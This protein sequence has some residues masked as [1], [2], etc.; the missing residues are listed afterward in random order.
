MRYRSVF[1]KTSKLFFKDM[2]YSFINK[3]IQALDKRFIMCYYLLSYVGV[4][5]I[6]GS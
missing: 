2:V 4:I 5:I 6:N 3:M 1:Q